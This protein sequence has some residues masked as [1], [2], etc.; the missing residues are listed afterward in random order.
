MYQLIGGK[1]S[2]ISISIDDFDSLLYISLFINIY[3]NTLFLNECKAGGRLY[4]YLKLKEVVYYFD[5]SILFIFYSNSLL[6]FD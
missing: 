5:I 4:I 3:E 2:Y 1:H 6:I